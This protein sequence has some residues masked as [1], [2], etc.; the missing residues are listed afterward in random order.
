MSKVYAFFINVN[1]EKHF[2]KLI[3]VTHAG[4]NTHA[5]STAWVHVCVQTRTHTHIEH[6]ISSYTAVYNRT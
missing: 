5:L 4:T 6:N 3:L 1:A 2:R